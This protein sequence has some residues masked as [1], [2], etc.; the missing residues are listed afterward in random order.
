MLATIATKSAFVATMLVKIIGFE[1]PFYRRAVL[2]FL[3][4]IL[5][6]ETF[7]SQQFSVAC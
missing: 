1:D 5:E 7:L 3:I 6:E 2:S 4:I